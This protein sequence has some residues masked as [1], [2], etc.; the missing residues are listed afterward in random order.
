M[1]S[2]QRSVRR[3]RQAAA[4]G[5]VRGHR[6]KRRQQKWAEPP[7]QHLSQPT[8]K[9]D[10]TVTRPENHVSRKDEKAARRQIMAAGVLNGRPLVMPT[11][12]DILAFF[13]QGADL[14][15]PPR[16]KNL[17]LTGSKYGV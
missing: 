11:F 4:S 7:R 12:E 17:T 8:G 6:S 10:I 16:T 1:S 2:F 3:N 14:Q 15:R 5:R 13:A 9:L